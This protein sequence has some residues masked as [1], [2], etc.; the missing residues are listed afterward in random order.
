M[1]DKSEKSGILS[2]FLA[3]LTKVKR[4]LGS[5]TKKQKTTLSVLLLFTIFS[6]IIFF[7]ELYLSVTESYPA[8]GGQISIGYV[9]GP[10]FINPVLASS[11]EIDKD[12]T[13]LIFA[14]LLKYEKDGSI[15][16]DLA[17]KVEVKEGGKL[18]EVKLKK[19]LKW[20]DGEPITADDVIFTVK[21]IQNIEYKSPLITSLTGVSVEKKDE[22]TFIFK[23][24]MPYA[25]FLERLADLKPIPKHIWDNIS[26]QDFLLA[27]FNLEAIGSGP[28]EFK[29][30]HIDNIGKLRSLD[31]VANNDYHG[32]KPFISKISFVFFDSE[33]NLK[34]ALK[35]KQIDVSQNIFIEN[36]KEIESKNYKLLSFYMPRYF[37]LFL[38][39]QKNDVLEQKEVREAI[40]KVI[41]I[42][43]IIN[44]I[45]KGRAI[46]I[47]SPIIPEFY[48]FKGPEIKYEYNPDEARQILEKAGFK[49]VDGKLV[50]VIEKKSFEF[51]RKLQVGSEGEDVKFLQQCLAKDPSIYPEGEVTGYFGQKTKEAVTRFQEKFFDEVLKPYGYTKGTGSTGAATIKKLN[52][53]C[54]EEPKIKEV[55]LSISIVDDDIFSKVAGQIAND[56][57]NLGFQVEIKKYTQSEIYNN[58]IKGRDYEM[59]LYGQ[60]L[61]KIPDPYPFWHSTQIYDPGLNIANYKNKKA[62]ELLE[63]IRTE[64]DEAKRQEMLENLQNIILEDIPAVFLYSLPLEIYVNKNIKNTSGFNIFDS[65]QKFNDIANWYIKEKR[66]LK[67]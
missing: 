46:K 22:L 58:V 19:N 4:I 16:G 15:K 29:E 38:N 35:S 66:S 11:K 24:Q 8:R 30:I 26:P 64:V 41:N 65:K 50:K 13:N 56:L 52:E 20:H 14:S 5:L 59:L 28:Y 49:V 42:D 21:L 44:D 18:Y 1:T 47:T 63:K 40:A 34:K 61:S 17:E 54:K 57:S 12:L 53:F 60:S 10:S 25:P 9:G 31:I 67:K 23:L 51:T 36:A 27:K 39:P 45:F 37:A 43:K 33:E 2:S 48:G 55:K 7:N 62:D 3:F 6:G 32:K